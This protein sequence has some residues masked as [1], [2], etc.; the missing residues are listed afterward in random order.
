MRKQKKGHD[1]IM[2]HYYFNRKTNN[3]DSDTFLLDSTKTLSKEW[4][5]NNP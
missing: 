1:K 4:E 5:N 2:S 3:P